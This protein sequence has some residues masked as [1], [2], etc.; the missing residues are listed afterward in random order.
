MGIYKEYDM[1]SSYKILFSYQ[2]LGKKMFKLFESKN[3][4]KP[5]FPPLKTWKNNAYPPLT[6]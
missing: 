6:L 2:K 5:F 1:T 4:K 3:N